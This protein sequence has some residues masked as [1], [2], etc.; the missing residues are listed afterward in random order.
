MSQTASGVLSLY[1]GSECQNV[2]ATYDDYCAAVAHVDET[3]EDVQEACG[4][5]FG[6][7]PLQAQVTKLVYS[8]ATLRTTAREKDGKVVTSVE[9]VTPQP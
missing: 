8:E 6:Y 3:V 1:V 4:L 5:T 2:L 9:W 7:F